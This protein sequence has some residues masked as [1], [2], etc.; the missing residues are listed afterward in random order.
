LDERLIEAEAEVER[1]KKDK[2][3]L[4]EKLV[5]ETSSAVLNVQREIKHVTDQFKIERERLIQGE[6]TPSR[7][8]NS[9]L[10]LIFLVQLRL[11]LFSCFYPMVSFGFFC[12]I[13]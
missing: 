12:F 10:M 3:T 6:A 7:L 9:P 1:L 8:S 4:S 2:A 11:V 13:F 5:E